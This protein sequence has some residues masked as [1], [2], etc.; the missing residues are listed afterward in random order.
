MTS[1]AFND[2]FLSFWVK[3]GD[4]STR[5]SD[6][7]AAFGSMSDNPNFHVYLLIYGLSALGFLLLQVS[8]PNYYHIGK[9]RN[10]EELLLL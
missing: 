8:L 1:K 6:D 5:N 10:R 7:D 2:L 3:E 9:L 4:G